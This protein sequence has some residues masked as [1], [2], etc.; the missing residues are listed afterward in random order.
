MCLLF[1]EN[2]LQKNVFAGLSDLLIALRTASKIC[3]CW[4]LLPLHCVN[5]NLQKNEFAGLSYLS[6]VLRTAS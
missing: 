6:L 2:S 4:F 5:N 1:V 3:V